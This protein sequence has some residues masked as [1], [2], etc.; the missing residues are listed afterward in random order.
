MPETTQIEKLVLITALVT[1]RH[2]EAE[3]F[4]ALLE[5]LRQGSLE[6]VAGET[7]ILQEMHSHLDKVYELIS[8][9]HTQIEPELFDEMQAHLSSETWE[10]ADELCAELVEKRRRQEDLLREVDPSLKSMETRLDSLTKLVDAARLGGAPFLNLEQ[11]LAALR[12]K[13]STVRR[14]LTDRIYGDLRESHAAALAEIDNFEKLV[15][16][17]SDQI[18]RVKKLVKQAD[19]LIMQ[20]GL[21]NGRFEYRVLLRSAD[22]FQTRGINIIQDVIT[23]DEK[24]RNW[25]LQRLGSVTESVN[26]GYRTAYARKAASSGSSVR[27]RGVTLTQGPSSKLAMLGEFMFRMV[28]PERVREYLEQEQ[29][30]FT[31]TT[32]DL[33]LPWELICLGRSAGINT[34]D[35]ATHLCLKRSISRMPLGQVFPPAASRNTRTGQERRMLLIHS[36]PDGTL[37]EAKSE[38]DMLQ[39]ELGGQL[40]ITR[41]DPDEATNANLNDILMSQSFDFFHYAGHAYFNVESPIESGLSLKDTILTADKI[42]RLNRGGSLVF[43]NACESG[44][45]AKATQAQQV[46]YLLH[47]PE[48]VVGLA[49]AFVYTGALGCVGSIWPVYDQPAAELAVKFYRNVLSGEPTGEALRRA[50]SE[51]RDQYPEEITWAAYVLYGDPTFRLVET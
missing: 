4:E 9:A 46:S 48:P 40:L 15:N 12:S 42:Q 20:A 16:D 44:T 7:A 49:S 34:T 11:G 38:V 27:P 50:R 39:Q 35:G 29:W 36:D 17:H 18:E 21:S 22:R 24:D 14:A 5:P 43:L 47:K 8:K 23:L 26:D 45:V 51:I 28:I 13:V 30:S 19:L 10:V 41:V 3:G 6:P 31:I 2:R 32:N 37:T 1:K 33:E 25:M